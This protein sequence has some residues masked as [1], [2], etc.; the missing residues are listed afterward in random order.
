M[1]INGLPARIAWRYLRAP[2]SYSAVSA[3]SIISVA[4]VAVATAAIV[5]VLSV[6]NGFRS[7]LSDTL[8]R[9]TPDIIVTPS[10]GKTFADADSLIAIISAAEGVGTAMPAVT[11]NALAIYD[12]RE[13]PITLRGVVPGE[14]SR[15]TSIDSLFLVGEGIGDYPS[16]AAVSIGVARQL[17]AGAGTDGLFIFAPRRQGRVNLSN[18]MASFLSDSLYVSGVFQSMQ[19]EFDDNSVICDISTARDLFQY[20][21]EA[22]AIEIKTTPGAD[23]QATVSDIESRLGET[24]IV[25]DRLRQQDTEFRMIEIEKWMTFLL[26]IFILMIASFN[27]ISTLCMLIIEKEPSMPILSAMGMTRPQ[28]AATFWWESIF[29]TFAGGIAGVVAGVILCLAQ[30]KFG[31]IKLAGDPEMMVVAAYPVVVKWEDIFISLLPVTVIGF[32]TAWISAAFARS[33]FFTGGRT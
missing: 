15:I 10:S 4:G 12:S 9:M 7:L 24:A 16:A 5:C 13:M 14:Y 21:T 6:F 3:I 18:P 26:L 22:T 8:D 33:R 23:L 28:I 11:D 29:V 27:I 25:K 30:E 20:T 1:K 19:T 32:I 2:K 31:I 17:G